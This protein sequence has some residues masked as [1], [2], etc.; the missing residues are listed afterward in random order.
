MASSSA[1]HQDSADQ[2][3]A[4]HQGMASSSA[5]HQDSEDDS[6]TILDSI[7]EV[8]EDAPKSQTVQDIEH[9]LIAAV[10]LMATCEKGY[11][12]A[13][14]K[15]S[16]ARSLFTGLSSQLS[17]TPQEQRKRQKTSG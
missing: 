10:E 2:G 3:K 15:L 7:I 14:R 6:R 8:L 5:G 1:G 11:E 17:S 4:E 16:A 12:A 9:Q 13:A